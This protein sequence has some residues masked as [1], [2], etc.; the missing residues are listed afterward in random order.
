METVFGI[1]GGCFFVIVGIVVFINRKGFSRFTADAQRATFGKAGEKVA[2]RAN[3][4]YTGAVGL[5]FVLAGAALVVVMLT[6]VEI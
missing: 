6:G 5:F 2:A 1:I 3:P 4:G